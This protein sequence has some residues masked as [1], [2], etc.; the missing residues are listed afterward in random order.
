MPHYLELA[1]HRFLPQ[2][3]AFA[4]KVGVPHDAADVQKAA[5]AYVGSVS[6]WIFGMLSHLWSGGLAIAIP[7]GPGVPFLY[8]TNVA[9]TIGVRFAF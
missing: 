6:S 4:A 3:T 9:P 8:P 2:L 1:R 5:G 7:H